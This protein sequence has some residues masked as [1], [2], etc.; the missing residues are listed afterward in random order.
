MTTVRLEGLAFAYGDAVPILEE[1]D[2]VLTQGWTGLVG[3]NGSGKTTLLRLLAGELHP[4]AGQVRLDP[5]CATV[6]VCTQEVEAVDPDIRSLAQRG[7]GVAHRLR[8]MLRL[9]TEMLEQWPTL[10]P[11]QRKRWQIGAAL[12]RDPEIL[13]LDEPTNHLDAEARALVVASLRRF[14]GLGVLVSHDRRL[15]EGLTDRTLRLHRGVARLYAGSYGVARALWEAELQAAWSRRSEAQQEAHR[16][17]LKL[18]NAR[19]TR[20]AAQRSRSGR[21]RNP[22]DRDARSMGAK[23]LRSWAEARLGGDVTRLRATAERMAGAVPDAPTQVE[24]GRSIFLGF[25]P[26]PGPVLLSL[27]TPEIRAGDLVLL[28]DVHVVVRRHDRLRLEGPNGSGKSTL[29]R[30]LLSASRLPD[31]RLL[32][33]S[34]ELPAIRGRELLEEVRSLAPDV[35][36]RVLSLVAALGTDPTR[37]LSSGAPSPGEARKLFLALGLARHV[38]G[39]IL[40]EPTNHLDLPTIERLEEALV[41]YPGAILLVTHDDRFASRCTERTWRIEG[42][43]IVT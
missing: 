2:L 42:Q 13:L 17:A 24:L 1:T 20:D 28:H 32:F 27:E 41:A 11:G 30:A 21:H 14:G 15:L 26:S 9:E 22:K 18:A 36:G 7:D 31:D 40:D 43:R 33:L 4:R 38:W 6:V 8:G 29:L 34:Q 23:T 19:R 12:A 35:R 39:L 16:A 25:S 37:L 3:E 10:S 5:E